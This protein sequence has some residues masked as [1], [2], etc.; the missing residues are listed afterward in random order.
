MIPAVKLFRE[1]L[2]EIINIL[3]ENGGEI[4]I[5]DK[6]YEYDSLDELEKETGSTIRSLEIKSRRPHVYLSF[7]R[8]MPGIHLFASA[9]DDNKAEASLLK[10]K[11]FLDTK[12]Q[13]LYYLFNR[14]TA[15]PFL[16]GFWALPHITIE[17][18]IQ[19]FPDRLM[20]ACIAISLI[21]VPLM[22]F[23]VE[24]GMI[25]SITL[26]KKHLA[27]GF[28]ARN[29]ENILMCIISATIGAVIARLIK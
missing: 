15:V 9:D 22:A 7:S 13:W 18:F 12:K 1:D 8:G 27:G 10:I 11:A 25:Y 4:S 2:E 28:W 26:K 16:L 17:K 23:V 5:S 6:K 19:I 29:R 3:K 20:R 14:V 24:T 21:V